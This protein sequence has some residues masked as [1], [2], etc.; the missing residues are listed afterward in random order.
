LAL[1]DALAEETRPTRQS[2]CG[3]RLAPASTVERA[4]CGKVGC[5]SVSGE[6]VGLRRA[7]RRE[8]RSSDDSARAGGRT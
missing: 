2:R 4:S 3:K 5:A 1:D 6:A 8:T 7:A